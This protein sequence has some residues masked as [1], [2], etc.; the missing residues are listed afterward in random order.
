[1]LRVQ[2][3]AQANK[4]IGVAPR[5]I[6]V[7]PMDDRRFAAIVDH[8]AADLDSVA[9]TNGAARRDVDVIDHFNRTRRGGCVERFV[10]AARTS[11]IEKAWR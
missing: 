4:T 8:F 7:R 6:V 3:A 10:R 2:T 11:P 5:R 1:M 9:D